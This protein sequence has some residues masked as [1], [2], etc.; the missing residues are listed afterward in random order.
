MDNLAQKKCIPCEGGTRPLEKDTVKKLLG[1]IPEWK[2]SDDYTRISRLF[3]FPTF[4]DAIAFVTNIATIAE[5][6][7]HHPDMKISYRKVTVTLTTHA[8]HGLSEND[9]I[10][11][12]KIDKLIST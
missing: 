7:N 2:P 6:E 11:A 4:M 10:M 12:A 1:Q 9:F 3:S 5:K 8:L